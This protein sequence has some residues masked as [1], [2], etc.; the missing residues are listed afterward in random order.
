MANKSG[1]EKV[2]LYLDSFKSG[3][4]SGEVDEVCSPLAR[5]PSSHPYPFW[6]LQKSFVLG[7]GRVWVW[8]GGQGQTSKIVPE[9]ASARKN[10]LGFS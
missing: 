5:D 4:L 8:V 10:T 1:L 9:L 6:S 3:I 2:L 7:K